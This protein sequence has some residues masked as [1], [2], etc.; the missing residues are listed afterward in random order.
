MKAVRKAQFLGF[1]MALRA[2]FELAKAMQ[3]LADLSAKH[4]QA[5]LWI[6]LACDLDVTRTRSSRARGTSLPLV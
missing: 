2:C 3:S 6:F 5:L 4:Y 1:S